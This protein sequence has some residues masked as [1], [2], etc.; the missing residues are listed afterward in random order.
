MKDEDEALSGLDQQREVAPSQE[1]LPSAKDK[2][3]ETDRCPGKK[4]DRCS[5]D[6]GS[7]TG[8]SWRSQRT[9]SVEDRARA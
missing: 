5:N 7:A 3:V 1:R 2:H 9:R 6:G 4:E 8:T